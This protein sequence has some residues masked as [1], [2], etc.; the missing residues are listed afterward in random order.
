MKKNC[1]CWFIL[2]YNPSWPYK[3]DS[4]ASNYG[5]LIVGLITDKAIS[6]YKRIHC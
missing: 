6:S 1:L 3:F 2:R 5:D 4:K